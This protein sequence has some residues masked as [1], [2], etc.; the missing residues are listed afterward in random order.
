MARKTR[1]RCGQHSTLARRR[2]QSLL[3]L[4]GHI[5]A[6]RH[7]IFDWHEQQLWRR[8]FEIGRRR[9]NRADERNLAAMGRK[10]EGY[11]LVTRDLA[12]ELDFQIESTADTI[13]DFTV[14]ERDDFR[15]YGGL[16]GRTRS[17]YPL[18]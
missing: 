9:G 11:A 18:Y 15:P 2:H 6:Y 10:P 3:V 8:N 14:Q 7:I 5:D 1:A 4:P 16:T 13:T 17:P 12:S